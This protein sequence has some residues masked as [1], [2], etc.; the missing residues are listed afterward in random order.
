MTQ[1]S[2]E[3]VERITGKPKASPWP[4]TVILILVGIILFVAMRPKPQPI[5]EPLPVA[6]RIVDPELEQLS[7]AVERTLALRGTLSDEPMVIAQLRATK[8]S[9]TI[10]R[11]MWVVVDATTDR[12]ATNQEKVDLIKAA[13]KE[14][15]SIKQLAAFV[16]RKTEPIEE[17]KKE[18]IQTSNSPAITAP[19]S[20]SKGEIL[21]VLRTTL[22]ASLTPAEHNSYFTGKRNGRKEIWIVGFPKPPTELQVSPYNIANVKSFWPEVKV[23]RSDD[24]GEAKKWFNDWSADLFSAIDYQAITGAIDNAFTDLKSK[25][26]QRGYVANGE[27]AWIPGD[28]LRAKAELQA[29]HEANGA[30]EFRLVVESLP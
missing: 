10:L 17:P 16:R 25:G 7:M 23:W 21:T 12:T 30:A 5:R 9:P 2:P 27:S 28:T 15:L 8:L 14:N 22:K 6:T 13:A 20:L 18:N 26:F 24:I 3:D 19:Q 11:D 1:Y 29:G 4:A